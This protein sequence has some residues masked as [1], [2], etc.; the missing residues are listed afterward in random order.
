VTPLLRR[1]ARSVALQ[2]R[3]A[4]LATQ[5]RSN[6]RVVVRRLPSGGGSTPLDG[7]PLMV[8]ASPAGDFARGAPLSNS[9]IR[10]FGQKVGAKEGL[11]RRLKAQS[12]RCRPAS[13]YSAAMSVPVSRVKPRLRGVFHEIGFYAAGRARDPARADSSGWQGP[14]R[15]ARV[16][17]LPRRLLWSERPLPPSHVAADCAGLAG[18]LDHAG[19]FLLI[20]GTYTPFGP[21]RHV[22]GMGDSRLG[23]S[24]GVARL[25]RSR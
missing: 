18:A 22:L 25:R 8:M 7:P 24:S 5:D 16:R 9:P 2:R 11:P 12:T 23:L 19:I 14:R 6:A 4:P 21:A 15:G 3:S 17:Q 20:A 1:S 13:A 10:R